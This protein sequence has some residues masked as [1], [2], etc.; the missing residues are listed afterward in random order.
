MENKIKKLLVTELL[1]TEEELSKTQVVNNTVKSV[2][3]VMEEQDM[4]E[5]A[6]IN[7]VLGW[8][9]GTI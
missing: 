4:A 5:D 2:Q 3:T 9:D 7:F 1:W 6:A 8:C